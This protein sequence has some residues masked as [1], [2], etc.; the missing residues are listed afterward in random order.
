MRYRV[1]QSAAGHV[2]VLLAAVA[3]SVALWLVSWVVPLAAILLYPLQLFATFVHEGAHAVAAVATGSAV[4]SLAVSPD[5]AGVVWTAGADGLLDRFVIASAGYVGTTVFGAGLLLWLRYGRPARTA[6]VG[7]ALVLALLTVVFGLMAPLASGGLTRT[8]VGGTLFTLGAGAVLAVGL[9]VVGRAASPR[10]ARFAVAFLAVQSLLNA[11]FALRD[12]IGISALTVA[13]SDAR[14]LAD[15]TG[16]P[17]LVW[18]LLWSAVS[19]AIIVAALRTFVVRGGRSDTAA[20]SPGATR[21]L[22]VTDTRQLG[23]GG[24]ADRRR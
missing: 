14:N 17:A 1:S 24:P 15:V 3:V 12:L 8:G 4:Q 22:P 2:G 18:A 10:W 23:A 20:G 16:V 21:V 5:T 19:V 9:L 6:L 11:V 13:H 7:S